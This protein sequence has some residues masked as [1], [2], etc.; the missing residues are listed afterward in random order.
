MS[1]A[2]AA[3]QAADSL[4][5]LLTIEADRT[6]RWRSH[7]CVITVAGATV[8]VRAGLRS[9]D[10]TDELDRDPTGSTIGVRVDPADVGALA[11]AMRYGFATLAI[12]PVRSGVARVEDGVAVSVGYVGDIEADPD[13][14]QITIALRSVADVDSGDLVPAS[15]T[16]D[17]TLFPI[18]PDASLSNRMP[19]VYGAPGSYQSQVVTNS[20]ALLLPDT[21][22]P[23]YTDQGWSAPDRVYARPSYNTPATPAYA[24]D[25][26]LTTITVAGSTLTMRVAPRYV[27]V[28]NHAVEAV[29]VTIWT[30]SDQLG[31]MQR[32]CNVVR[33][34]DGLDR[35]ISL[36]YIVDKGSVTDTNEDYIFRRTGEWWCAWDQGRASSGLLT[37]VLRSVLSRSSVQ[38]DWQSIEAA[39]S[40]LDQFAIGGYLDESIT[41]LEWAQSRLP[42]YGAALRWSADGVGIVVTSPIADVFPVA[43]FEIGRGCARSAPLRVTPGTLDEAAVTWAASNWPDAKPQTTTVRREAVPIPKRAKVDAPECWDDATAV[44]VGRV[45]LWRHGPEETI[46]IAVDAARWWWLRAGDVVDLTDAATG[47]AAGD[48]SR[49]MIMRAQHTDGQKRNLSLRRIVAERISVDVVGA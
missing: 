15:M 28:A 25:Y 3:Q 31:W 40:H 35:T 33:A 6:Y 48:D 2:G 12:L 27:V 10:V 36:A 19:L 14:G 20:G 46:G 42:T 39:R 11:R 44:R 32:T 21:Y 37:D 9:D 34:Y 47:Y 23:V 49:W 18:A 45:A 7:D 8:A 41:P 17:K 13:T 16:I 1:A 5:W 4:V 29:N 43:R 30:K 24:I 22:A 38:V 26:E